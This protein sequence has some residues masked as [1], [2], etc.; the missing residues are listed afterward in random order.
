MPNDAF[1]MQLLYRMGHINFIKILNIF[2]WIHCTITMRQ[3]TSLW[4]L[5][6]FVKNIIKSNRKK[7]VGA[8]V[9]SC[10]RTL[11]NANC[12]V[13]W[14]SHQYHIRPIEHIDANRQKW[15]INI[16]FK[17]PCRISP[18]FSTTFAKVSTS[19]SQLR[20]RVMREQASSRQPITTDK[21][22]QTGRW[23]L[24]NNPFLRI[25]TWWD[26]DPGS[27]ATIYTSSNHFQLSNYI[28][29]T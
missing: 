20:S 15:S 29:A 6:L 5:H 3:L 14:F 1:E 2:S 16:Y 18:I 22:N 24:P 8:D 10:H 28:L 7:M 11:K 17:R 9:S 13:N 26:S 21:G 12:L 23:G 4:T 19:N 25:G 27:V